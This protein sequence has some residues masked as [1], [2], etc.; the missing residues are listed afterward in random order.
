MTVQDLIARANLREQIQWSS[1]QMTI[2]RHVGERAVFDRWFN[3]SDPVTLAASAQDQVIV[4]YT[5]P[6]GELGILRA[7]SYGVAVFTDFDNI[8]FALRV[9]RQKVHGFDNMIG[10]LSTPVF[11]IPIVVPLWKGSTVEIVAS[12]L[13]AVAIPLVTAVLRGTQFPEDPTSLYERQGG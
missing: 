8:R 4:G 10:P 5:L 9:D 13:T 1:D 7:F 12:N 2:L 11:P 3:R 6:G